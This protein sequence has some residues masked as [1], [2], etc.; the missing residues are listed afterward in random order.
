MLCNLLLRCT[1]PELYEEDDEPVQQTELEKPVVLSMDPDSN[2]SMKKSKKTS[3][4][5]S[6]QEALE[7]KVGESVECAI[8]RL[9]MESIDEVIA[10][11]STEVSL[12]SSES[13]Y[14]IADLFSFF[15]ES[16][17][18]ISLYLLQKYSPLAERGGE[19]R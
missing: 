4:I 8:C 10:S 5:Y 7:K 2:R 9:A 1:K 15:K 18:L 3:A 12:I 13:A 6:Q 17:L 14:F 16:F 11:N 19:E